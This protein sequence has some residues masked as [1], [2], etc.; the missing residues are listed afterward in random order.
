[1]A[2]GMPKIGDRL[3][4]VTKA[5]LVSGLVAALVVGILVGIWVNVAA[6]VLVGLLVFLAV[7]V[8]ALLTLE[9]KDSTDNNPPL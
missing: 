3:T 1:M 5:A 2:D 4:P 9:T 8:V 7:A 6:G